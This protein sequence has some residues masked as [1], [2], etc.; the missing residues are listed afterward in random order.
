[1]IRRYVL[2]RILLRNREK[3]IM[4]YNTELSKIKTDF[5]TRSWAIHREKIAKLPKSG[6]VGLCK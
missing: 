1:M 3:V 5:P 6:R 4:P 2:E